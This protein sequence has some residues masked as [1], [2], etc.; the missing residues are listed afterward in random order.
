MKITVLEIRKKSFEKNFRGYDTDE[1]DS[2]LRNLS[3]EWEKLVSENKELQKKLENSN[4]EG[5]KLKEVESS[6]FRTLK[7]AEDT[8]ASIIEEAND[9][10]DYIVR[11]AQQN[12]QAMLN[13][14]QTQSKNLIESAELKGAQIMSEL[15]GDV[16]ELVNGYETMVQQ[17]ELILKNLKKLAEDIENN[18]E[19]SNKDLENVNIRSHMSIV[20]TLN[21]SNSFTIANIKSL[22]HEE[23]EMHTLQT[24]EENNQIDANDS[25]LNTA[26]ITSDNETSEIISTTNESII[27][28]T[29]AIENQD[30][31]QME[32]EVIGAAKENAKKDLSEE[33]HTVENESND[34]LIVDEDIE[35]QEYK[36]ENNKKNNKNSF[37]D[38]LE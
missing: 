38:D 16:S 36:E 4:R 2:F 34:D 11:E 29:V 37:F 20:E 32:E 30:E 6:L 9:A 3:E 23:M 24:I 1:V 28:D 22:E 14:A 8:G 19:V 27:D 17:R 21:K 10:A 33:E 18:I 7:T 26:E 5:S 31:G 12:A 25:E 35:L 13:D 15:K